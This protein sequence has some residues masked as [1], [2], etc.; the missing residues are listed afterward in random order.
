[1]RCSPTMTKYIGL[2]HCPIQRSLVFSAY[3]FSIFTLIYSSS[4]C[5]F[6]RE[7]SDP[8]YPTPAVKIPAKFHQPTP[9]LKSARGHNGRLVHQS[10]LGRHHSI[11]S[12]RKEF[13]KKFFETFD[14]SG[15]LSWSWSSCWEIWDGVQVIF[16]SLL[17]VS[18]HPGSY[19][20]E[21]WFLA[22]HGIT[23]HLDD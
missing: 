2:A 21:S 9:A 17:R 20:P 22:P 13:W 14:A 10:S 12:K 7:L 11:A 23:W 5:L 18:P 4:R 16:D 6:W 3:N 19:D 8:Q 1:M 15:K